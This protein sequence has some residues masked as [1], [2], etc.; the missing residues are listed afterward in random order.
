MEGKHHF[1]IT[2]LILTIS[3]FFN[4]CKKDFKEKSDIIKLELLYTS[5][6]NTNYLYSIKLNDGMDILNN[7]SIALGNNKCSKS[8]FIKNNV[9]QNKFIN[10]CGVYD[11]I[12]KTN[13]EFDNLL[14]LNIKENLIF[15]YGLE[16]KSILKF[17]IKNNELSKIDSIKPFDFQIFNNKPL[18]DCISSDFNNIIIMKT[19][20]N[21]DKWQSYNFYLKNLITENEVLILENVKGNKIFKSSNAI[22]VPSIKWINIREFVYSDYKYS[23]DELK[24]LVY[25]FN[26][27][28]KK[29]ELIG[30]IS[31][32]KETSVNLKFLNSGNE[33]YL[34]IDN[35]FYKIDS[36]NNR[37]F[38]DDFDLGNSFSVS[39]ENEN[40]QLKFNGMNI[41]GDESKI[42]L[43]STFE[44]NPDFIRIHDDKIILMY[45]RRLEG[46]NP[47]WKN[48]CLIWSNKNKRWKELEINRASTISSFN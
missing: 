10:S 12:N 26:I 13:F 3:L 46:L 33:L 42:P 47:I 30:E 34:K 19:S 4:S 6:I 25:K 11:L 15:L 5:N 17:D 9:I 1:I 23:N 40:Y 16:E 28:T 41:K 24:C 43:S 32:L 31:N 27:T 37:V 36:E 35:S 18:M 38:N 7:D 22:S 45:S 39:I 20:K 21:I 8:G 29:R 14:P 48:T 44:L 2:T